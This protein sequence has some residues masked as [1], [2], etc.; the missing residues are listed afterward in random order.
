MCEDAED[1]VQH[2]IV[3]AQMGD[4]SENAVRLPESMDE[5]LYHADAERLGELP[6]EEFERTEIG[7]DKQQEPRLTSSTPSRPSRPRGPSSFA[8]RVQ[9]KLAATA[10][11]SVVPDGPRPEVSEETLSPEGSQGTPTRSPAE[12]QTINP[13]DPCLDVPPRSAFSSTSGYQVASSSFLNDHYFSSASPESPSCVT[14]RSAGSY[15]LPRPPSI[16]GLPFP[17]TAPNLYAPG[18]LPSAGAET[19]EASYSSPTKESN[20]KKSSIMLGSSASSVK[21]KIQE[22][23]ERVRAA[24]G[25]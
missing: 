3:S 21:A 20:P 25:Y 6:E 14:P 12:Q 5:S 8:L 16:V 11:Q 23:E 13:T 15:V 22:L 1:L 18:P 9:N 10:R 24:E 17:E 4:C 2:A 7:D 19:A